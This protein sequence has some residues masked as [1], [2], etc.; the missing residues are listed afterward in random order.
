MEDCK[1]D[2]IRLVEHVIMKDENLSEIRAYM[3]ELLLYGTGKLIV[4]DGHLRHKSLTKEEINELENEQ[5]NIIEEKTWPFK[6]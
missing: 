1:S 4:E 3:E 2:F 6:G 5:K